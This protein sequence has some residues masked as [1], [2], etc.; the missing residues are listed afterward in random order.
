[1]LF[2]LSPHDNSQFRFAPEVA[3]FALAPLKISNSMKKLLIIYLLGCGI[4]PQLLSAKDITTDQ[5]GQF[6]R[7]ELPGKGILT[8]A[9][10]EINVGGKNIANGGKTSQSSVGSGGLPERAIDGNKDGSYGKKGQTHTAE[11]D[12]PWWEIDLG[13]EHQI[14]SIQIW[15]RTELPERLSG[16]KLSILD[17]DRKPV[18]VKEKIEAPLNS[19]Q[20]D[21]GKKGKIAY[22]DA[23]GGKGKIAKTK[24]KKKSAPTP[25]LWALAT[26]EVPADHRDPAEFAFQPGDVVTLLGNGLAERMQYDGWME[27]LIQS[28]EKDKKLR[29]RNAAISG[30]RVDKFPRN[31]GFMPVD[32][33]LQHTK[34]NVVFAFFG[35]NESFDT[36]PEDYTKKLGDL[37]AKIRA[38]KP[39][40][41]F[42]R[43]VL[44]SPIA[45]ENLGSSNFPD[46][47][48]NNQRLAAIT[49]ATK[50][51]SE[52]EGVTFVDL[53]TPSKALYEANSEPLTINGIHLNEQGNKLIGEVIAKALTGA[54]VKASESLAAL[55]DAVRDKDVTWFDRH[56][57]V[58]G[59]DIWGSRSPLHFVGEQTNGDVLR[60]ELVMLDVMTANRDVKIW[61]RAKGGDHDVLDENVPAPLEVISNVGGKGNMSNATKEGNVNYL[62]AE[63]SIATM[64]VPDEFQLNVFADES[65]FPDLVN[66]V[67]MQVDGKG[68]LWVAAWPTYPK[69]KP[70]RNVNDSLLIFEDTDKDGKADKVTK[71]AEV[72]NP[73][74]F[75][76]WGGGVIV[77]SQPNLVFLK[78]TDGDDIADER[79]KIL[80]GVGSADT[81]H[82]CNNL[83]YGPDG[84]IYWQ[85]GIFL[86][87]NFEHP[88]GPSLSTGSSAMY[89]F[90]PRRFTIAQH[91]S[92]SPNPHGISFDYWGYHYATDGTGGRAYQV[93]P[94]GSG[95]KMHPLL[96][97]EVRPV[98]AS[99]ILS[100][101][102]FPE[103]MQQDF[104]ICNS[105]GFLGLKQ[106]RLDR[107]GEGS[108]RPVGEV[109]GEPS[110]AELTVSLDG[111]ESTSRGLLLSGDKNFRPTDAIV[112]EDGALYVS[113]WANVI[114]GHM[115]HNIR[116]PNRDDQHGRVIRISHKTRPLQEP[117]KIAGASLDELMV[118]LEHP[119][120]GVR[121]RTRVEL[122]AR[123][124]E[125]VIAACQKW[126]AQWDKKNPDHAHHLLEA[127]WLHQA[128]NVRDSQLLTAVL[129]SPVP[130]ARVAAQ[131]VQHH[132]Y[133]AD[134]AKGGGSVDQQQHEEAAKKSGIIADSAD[135]TEIRIATL[136]EKM[137][138]DTKELTIKAGK[139]IRL[140]FANPDFMP[141]NLLVVQPGSSTE[142]GTAAMAL[143]AEGFAKQFRPDSDKIIAGT[144]MLDNGQEETIEFYAPEKPGNYEFV[145]TFP[146]HFMLMKGILKV[147]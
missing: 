81:H 97:K 134:P 93:R 32:A 13:A 67:Q 114:I 58:D 75:E 1:M 42:P 91:G 29:F 108:E 70:I 74:G 20:I 96:D 35:Y 28:V 118:N 64:D 109:W 63:D 110:G 66:P 56:R 135:L 38:T 83:I 41:A 143:G 142:V 65:Q 22:F 100:S 107:G 36:K 25:Q 78:D 69:Q 90:D 101:A 68:R 133:A 3:S 54:E 130:H 44:F 85:S 37:V 138:Y 106:Y 39:A 43:I 9:E 17:S 131:T 21:I 103:E 126:M 144:K 76:F 129:K 27:T 2:S 84:G 48:A 16:F 45:H 40:G 145:C 77:S 102:H 136:V 46:G 49:A 87:N 111:K 117:V 15:N 86:H 139:K 123:D 112:G 140:T 34:A 113:D 99:E 104:L 31:K 147:K 62:S 72:P 53:F 105:I 11:Q 5:P 125:E 95:W 57:A 8:L 141:H 59:N 88:W 119:I 33:Y 122:S 92:N 24:P 89:R 6:V 121:H 146:G 71:F 47:T 26:N 18:F 51:A 55:R 124:S 120:D 23:K 52:E 94:E 115:Q 50:A 14:E 132:W 80:H 12:K 7:I 79:I 73:L 60:H 116:D 127:L 98:P 128:H 137:S 30:D 82:A 19:I 10:V 61:A 4:L